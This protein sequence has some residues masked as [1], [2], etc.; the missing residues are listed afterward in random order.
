MQ[1]SKNV[2]KLNHSNHLL[3]I[4]IDYLV[5]NLL[6]EVLIVIQLE[7]QHELV[8]E[9][10]PY[11]VVFG[12]EVRATHIGH[13]FLVEFVGVLRVLAEHVD[14]EVAFFVAPVLVDEEHVLFF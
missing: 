4:I 2:S 5:E 7:S 3:N 14:G 1:T 8:L 12:V 9:L 6:E 10:G 11:L 13:Q